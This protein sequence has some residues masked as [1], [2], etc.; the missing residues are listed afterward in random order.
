MLKIT[1]PFQKLHVFYY[2][3]AI[4]KL[5]NNQ[6]SKKMK[7]IYSKNSV[8]FILT[9]FTAG[10]SCE[11]TNAQIPG[12]HAAF[13]FTRLGNTITFTDSSWFDIGPQ[14]TTW[15]WNFGDGDTS[16]LQNPVHTYTTAQ[17]EYVVCLTVT[18]CSTIGG[19]CCTDTHCD[20][21]RFN[22]LTGMAGYSSDV[23]GF[24]ISPNPANNYISISLPVEKWDYQIEIFNAPGETI[25]KTR[26]KNT[27]DVS[28]FSKGIYF[29]KVK[30]GE[31]FYIQ[32]FIKL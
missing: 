17:S 18:N 4:Q 14:N 29:I 16:T 8:R 20:T 25:I 13:T 15:T 11:T 10:I 12:C 9:L 7:K 1:Q 23:R 26:N 6:I 32:K 2:I 30:D 3:Y 27:I 21:I 22:D 24:L 31:N 19:L 5:T 28:L